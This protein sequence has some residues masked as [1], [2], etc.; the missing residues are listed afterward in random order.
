MYVYDFLFGWM[1]FCRGILVFM[2]CMCLKAIASFHCNNWIWQQIKHCFVSE[3][4]TSSKIKN[5]KKVKYGSG[6]VS[7]G[8]HFLWSFCSNKG[9][10]FIGEST[11]VTGVGEQYAVNNGT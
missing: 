7:E 4:K 11:K 1:A 6:P 9:C 3:G 2:W 8:V 10:H 5:E